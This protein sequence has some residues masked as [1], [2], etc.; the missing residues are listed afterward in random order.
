MNECTICFDAISNE[1]DVL[2]SKCSSQHCFHPICLLQWKRQFRDENRCPTCHEVLKESLYEC[3]IRFQAHQED[4]P[5]KKL[6]TEL[7]ADLKKTHAIWIRTSRFPWMSE[8]EFRKLK[9][10][11]EWE[12]KLLEFYRNKKFADMILHQVVLPKVRESDLS[13]E[14]TRE[15]L[16]EIRNLLKDKTFL[17][18]KR[19]IPISQINHHF[20]DSLPSSENY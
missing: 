3:S 4:L 8:E 12:S 19:R 11:P 15:L 16:E 13:E 14:K 2:S 5:K 10:D 6:M 9:E 17:R 20:S 7:M 18:S 1:I